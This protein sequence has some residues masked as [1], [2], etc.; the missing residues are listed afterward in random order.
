[1]F[2]PTHPPE[3]SP[4]ARWMVGELTRLAQ[5]LERDRALVRLTELTSAPSRI[6]GDEIVRADGTHWNPGA[7][8]GVYVQ[9]AGVWTKL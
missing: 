1:M 2:R 8:Q 9:V 7:G 4:L 5:E 6:Y 3:D